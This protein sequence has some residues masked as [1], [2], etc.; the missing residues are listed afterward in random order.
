MSQ[1]PVHVMSLKGLEFRGSNGCSTVEF[2]ITNPYSFRKLFAATFL[3]SSSMQFND[4]R[5]DQYFEQFTF[6]L[7]RIPN[8]KR[9]NKKKNFFLKFLGCLIPVLFEKIL[10]FSC[11]WC[12]HR[13]RYKKV[14][15]C[16]Q[17]DLGSRSNDRRN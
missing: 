13:G 12:I 5:D 14:V 17:R 6:C 16:I 8:I 1:L 2:Q 15:R 11:I 3:L 10:I 9:E 4:W 7:V